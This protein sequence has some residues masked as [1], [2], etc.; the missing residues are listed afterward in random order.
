MFLNV[1]SF[2]SLISSGNLLHS[3]NAVNLHDFCPYV[4]FTFGILE[5]C[6]LKSYD[7]SVFSMNKL[8]LS[9]HFT[10]IILKTEIKIFFLRCL[11]EQCTRF[12]GSKVLFQ[13]GD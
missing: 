11:A 8:E 13:T 6:S 1:M 12:A 7:I 2:V 10:L 4:V 3:F 5:D 9:F